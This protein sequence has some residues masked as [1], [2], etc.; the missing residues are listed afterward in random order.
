MM[1]AHA[2]PATRAT[3]RDTTPE[4]RAQLATVFA[5]AEADQPPLVRGRHDIDF[6]TGA[7]L[8]CDQ[9]HGPS[10][11][12]EAAHLELAYD[13]L[14]AALIDAYG[15]IAELEREKGLALRRLVHQR[16]AA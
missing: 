11:Q 12:Q 4:I 15:R 2:N 7:C 5:A 6:T 16:K 3:I 14:T 10:R 13:H 1:S 9:D 8:D